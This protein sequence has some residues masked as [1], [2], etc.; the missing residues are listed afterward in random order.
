VDVSLVRRLDV[1]VLDESGRVCFG[2]GKVDPA[3]L[4]DLLAATAPD[5]VAIDSPPAWSARGGS[6]LIERQ[7]LALGIHVYATPEDPGDHPFYHWM[8]V[9]FEAFKVVAERG[10]ALY[11]G[12]PPGGRCAIEVFPHATAVTLRG[13]LP[14]AG[15][16]KMVWRRRALEESGV[17]CGS[18]V[19]VDAVDAALAALTGIRCLLGRFCLVGEPGG[20][21]LVLPV[22]R[23]PAGRYTRGPA[24][25]AFRGRTEK[26]QSKL[27]VTQPHSTSPT[28]HSLARPAQSRTAS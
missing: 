2:P 24:A 16:P 5:I 20:A 3:G 10:Y 4:P 21:V 13:A 12:G 17:D 7:L 11:R 27:P 26:T 14:P 18:L 15:V 23:L 1:V 9:G 19:T 28:T 8:R 25:L 6:R 22:P